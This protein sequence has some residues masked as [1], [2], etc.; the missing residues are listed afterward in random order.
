MTTYSITIKKR[1]TQHQNVVM[2]SVVSPACSSAFL[3]VML[4]VVVPLLN[5][6]SASNTLA[7]H[8]NASNIR[9]QKVLFSTS[10]MQGHVL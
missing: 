1:D 9:Q 6:N 2:L 3:I 4:S 5:F 7:Y 10:S 8:A